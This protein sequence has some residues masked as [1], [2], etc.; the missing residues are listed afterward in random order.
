MIGYDDESLDE[1]SLD[2]NGNS[3][4]TLDVARLTFGSFFTVI[5]EHGHP[6]VTIIWSTP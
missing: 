2:C 3:D 1:T 6:Y 4:Q 5:E